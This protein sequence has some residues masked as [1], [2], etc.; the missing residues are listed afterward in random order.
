MSRS[1]KR[2]LLDRYVSISVNFKLRFHGW[3]QLPRIWRSSLGVDSRCPSFWKE[4]A[5]F[6]IFW[7]IFFQIPPSCSLEW[8]NWRLFFFQAFLV[9]HSMVKLGA[10]NHDL[11]QR[12]AIF[13]WAAMK[14]EDQ[15]CQIGF[16]WR[17]WWKQGWGITTTQSYWIGP[18]LWNWKRA[19]LNT[20]T[21]S[22]HDR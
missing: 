19:L 1:K 17:R 4:G 12:R 15:G 13:F 11:L 3:V 22:F 21:L 18:I 2:F 7:R 16:F 6:V 14:G 9:F 10:W 5:V 20:V 8:R